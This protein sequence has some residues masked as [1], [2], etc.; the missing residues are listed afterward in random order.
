MGE[1]PGYVVQLRQVLGKYVHAKKIMFWEVK[2]I[3]DSVGLNQLFYV[4]KDSNM[5][6]EQTMLFSPIELK[7][8]FWPFLDLLNYENTINLCVCDSVILSLC[9][10][11]ILST[12]DRFVFVTLVVS[13]Y[14]H[15]KVFQ[16]AGNFVQILLNAIPRDVFYF[17]FSIFTVFIYFFSILGLSQLF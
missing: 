4:R 12:C 16:S 11:V 15:L 13:S 7:L 2:L 17:R 9:D 5:V 3:H 1:R 6:S 14:L 8:F 10:S